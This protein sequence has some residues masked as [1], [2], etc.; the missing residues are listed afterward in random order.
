MNIEIVIKKLSLRLVLQQ[1]AQEGQYCSIAL[2]KNQITI[3]IYMYNV[4]PAGHVFWPIIMTGNN[5]KDGH[6]M[7]ISAKLFK[8]KYHTLGGEDFKSFHYIQIRQNSPA[9]YWACLCTMFVYHST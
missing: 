4:A 9:P 5:L 3:A 7:N 1:E 6:Q 8:N 2:G